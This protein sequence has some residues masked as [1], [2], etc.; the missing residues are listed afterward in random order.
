MR[1]TWRLRVATP[2]IG[3]AP[4]GDPAAVHLDRSAGAGQPGVADVPGAVGDLPGHTRHAVAV[5]S[6]V[7]PSP[8]DLPGR[9]PVGPSALGANVVELVLRLAR[10]NPRWGYVRIVGECRKLGAAVSATS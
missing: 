1:R 5:A 3:A 6:R 8:L 2:A 9:W 10:E 7:G 4:A